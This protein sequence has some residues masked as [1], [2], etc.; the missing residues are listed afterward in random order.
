MNLKNDCFSEEEDQAFSPHPH[1]IHL[2][3]RKMDFQAETTH[4]QMTCHSK[5]MEMNMWTLLKLGAKQKA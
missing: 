3:K 2:N 5:V 1:S 4:C